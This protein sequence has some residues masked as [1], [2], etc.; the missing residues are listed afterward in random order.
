MNSK[1]LDP[2][3]WKDGPPICI[4]ANLPAFPTESAA[5]EF[6]DA[7]GHLPVLTR[8]ECK[9]CGGWHHWTT[10]PTDSNGAFKGGAEEMPPRIAKLAMGWGMKVSA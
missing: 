10:A 6:N 5:R 1:L 2:P 3:R 4:Q 8:W 7:H 9:A